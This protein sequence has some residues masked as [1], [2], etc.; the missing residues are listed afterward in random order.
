MVKHTQ[1][2]RRQKPRNCLS[3]FD[4]FVKLVLKGLT[5]HQYP[6]SQ[7]R[8]S[9]PVASLATPGLLQRLS[10]KERYTF[11]SS[12]NK[13]EEFSISICCCC[14]MVVGDCVVELLVGSICCWA[15]CC[16]N[17]AIIGYFLVLL[18]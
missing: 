1:T 3:M 10:H 16:C 8:G 13:C 5:N 12:I 6:I 9:R 14:G 2:I 11:T 15:G 18:L 4:H 7:L 17:I